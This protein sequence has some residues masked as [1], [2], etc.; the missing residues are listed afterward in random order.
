MAKSRIGP[1]TKLAVPRME[2][3][4]AVLSKRCRT[5]IEKEMRYK[6]ERVI[7]LI[8]SET[9]LNQLNRTSYRFKVYEGVRIG[10]IQ[11][12]PSGDMSEWAW[13]PGKQNIADWLT[14]GCAPTE[15][16]QLS[17]WQTGPPMLSEPFENWNIKFGSTSD[18]TL[19]GEK[20]ITSTN[21]CSGSSAQP[22][23]LNYENL[24]SFQ[25]AIKSRCSNHGHGKK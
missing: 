7:H 25:K 17:A 2:L 3:N 16:D 19:P 18:E 5:V 11:A 12:A 21:L 9:V 8:D 10:E 15:L 13:L 22:S 6:F 14:R 20:K 23:L 1:V 24:R 4:G